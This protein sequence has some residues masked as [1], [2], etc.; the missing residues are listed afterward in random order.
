MLSLHKFLKSIK[1]LNQRTNSVT[2]SITLML[3]WLEKNENVK[4]VTK[5]LVLTWWSMRKFPEMQS[6][7]VS[8]NFFKSTAKD[9]QKEAKKHQLLI[10][11][12]RSHLNNLSPKKLFKRG[13]Y[14]SIR[15]KSSIMSSSTSCILFFH[16]KYS[17]DLFQ[18]CISTRD[19]FGTYLTWNRMHEKFGFRLR[20][21]RLIGLV[22]ICSIVTHGLILD[23]YI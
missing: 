21:V 11:F 10:Q 19:L 7:S 5:Y 20:R 2:R 12:P 22:I 23:S 3:E 17:F 1:Q 8:F 13:A 15:L 14:F 16:L 9:S 18:F 4:G 6:S